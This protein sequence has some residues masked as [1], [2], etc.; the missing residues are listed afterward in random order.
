MTN[1]RRCLHCPVFTYRY[2]FVNRPKFYTRIWNTNN[3]EK[4]NWTGLYS[5]LQEIWHAKTPPQVSIHKLTTASKVLKTTKWVKG[6]SFFLNPADFV[7]RKTVNTVTWVSYYNLVHRYST[8]C[9][10]SP[11]RTKKAESNK[12]FL[13]N[14]VVLADLAC[15]NVDF[16]WK[17]AKRRCTYPSVKKE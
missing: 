16:A 6:D 11:R 2:N 17:N 15:E 10:S 4:E 7:P 14:A 1:N 8:G 12:H 13:R 9:L 5:V 3:G